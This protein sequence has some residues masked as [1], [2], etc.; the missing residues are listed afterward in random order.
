MNAVNFIER[1]NERAIAWWLLICCAVLLVLVIVG[2]ATRLT[3]SG[4]SMVEWQPLT[5]IP[6]LNEEAWMREF[7]AYRASLE[8]KKVNHGMSL[9]EFK[10]IFWWE[11]GHRQLARALGL[12]YALPLIWFW[13]RGMVPGRLRWP[14]VGLL[15]LGGL[16]GYMGWFMVQSGLVDIPRVSPYRLAAHLS[17]ALI[18]Y[19]IM[20]RIALGLLWPPEGRR[21]GP[22]LRPWTMT[23]LV[24]VALTIFSGA[25]VAGLNAGLVYNTF[26]LM[27]GRLVPEGYLGLE[28][29]WRN[30]FENTAAVQFNHR[31]L[32]IATAI[33]ALLAW[34]RVLRRESE[35]RVR[36]AFHALAAIMLIQVALGIATLLTFV[37]VTLGTIH[38]G[39]AVL[40]LTAVIAAD[41]LGKWRVAL[42]QAPAHS[43]RLAEI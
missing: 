25:F 31:L 2:G 41:Y 30:L 42:K 35:Q 34:W 28:P 1:H 21:A 40:V 26:P 19:A 24:L 38:Q 12:V 17:L 11:F 13:W 8:Y 7:D 20:F 33:V 16:Q 14:L 43:G 37:P 23:L 18:I 6:P 5:V 32:A 27:A 29:L 10:V 15:A 39:A 22:S 4:L 9:S 3:G 36:M